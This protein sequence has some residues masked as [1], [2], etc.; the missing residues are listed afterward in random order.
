MS[1][2]IST[3]LS[4]DDYLKHKL[5][6]Q[7]PIENVLCA[8][9]RLRFK[10]TLSQKV[11]LTRDEVISYIELCLLDKDSEIP[12]SLSYDLINLCK[13][14]DP[15]ALFLQAVIYEKGLLPF[16]QNLSKSFNLYYEAYKLGYKK[17]SFELGRCYF[18]GI[19]IDV[20]FDLAESYLKQNLDNNKAKT[21]LGYIYYCKHNKQGI[22]LLNEANACEEIESFYYLGLINEQSRNYEKAL[23]FYRTGSDLGEQRCHYKAGFLLY[24]SDNEYHRKIAKNYL[25]RAK[26]NKYA[27]ELLGDIAKSENED[28]L[29]YYYQAFLKGAGAKK[30]AVALL[31][32][33]KTSRKGA[34]ILK[35]I[36]KTD[37]AADFLLF[38][39]YKSIKEDK[40]ARF[41][42]KRA[43]AR[44]NDDA[45]KYAEEYLPSLLK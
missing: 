21:Y 10:I 17:A 37:N 29:N 2:K 25:K 23:L 38:K 31:E 43:I 4:G 6:E 26:D 3:Y 44:K 20:N 45:L 28:Y 19:G 36:A 40:T 30:Y 27:L 32:N 33:P 13:N 9:E 39:Y 16:G 24:H 11:T 8:F 12:H 35:S 22:K 14:K 7:L 1:E 42:L 15:R 5:L 41:Y 18:N 34:E